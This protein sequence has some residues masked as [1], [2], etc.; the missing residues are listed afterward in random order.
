MKNITEAKDLKGKKVLLRLDLNVPV[1]D[2]EVLNDFRIK[3]IL[4]TIDFLKEHGAKII[5]ISHIVREK[6]ETFKPVFNYLKKIMDIVFVS[7]VLNDDASAVVNNMKDGDIVMIEN[8]RQHEGEKNNDESFSKQIARLGDIYVNEAFANSHRSHSSIVGIPQFLPSYSGILFQ[9]EI[10]ALS[11]SFKPQSPFLFI[12]GGN[13][14]KTKLSL[15]EKMAKI[16]DNVF[17]GGALANDF[18]KAKGLNVGTSFISDEPVDLS[19]LIKNEKIIL[20]VDVVVKNEKG[21]VQTKKPTDVLSGEKI[22]DAGDDT[23]SQL[24]KLVNDSKFVLFNGPLGDYEKGFGKPTA[25][26][27]RIIGNSDV[28]SIVGGGDTTAIISNLGI[29]DQFTFVSTGGGAMLDFLLNETLPG[30]KALG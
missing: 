21:D 8:L 20:P 26:L 7:D 30:I 5:I 19:N 9:K 22:L 28:N 2:G 18:F 15:I 11:E 1:K 16:A 24:L 23:V 27:I 13:K 3:K 25:E 14:L 4:P 17:V 29:E 12:I 10:Q 6:T